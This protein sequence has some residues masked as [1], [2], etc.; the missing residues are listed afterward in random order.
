[1]TAASTPPEQEASHDPRGK[2]AAR[3]IRQPVPGIIAAAA[4]GEGLM[5]LVQRAD[6]GGEGEAAEN[7]RAPRGHGAGLTKKSEQ[8]AGGTAAEV[9]AV[10]ELVLQRKRRPAGQGWI[11]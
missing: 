11:R 8:Q 4:G 9:E 7:K 3:H 5:I 10:E 1:M 6:D 2:H